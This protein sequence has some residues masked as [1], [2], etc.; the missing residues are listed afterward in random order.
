[1]KSAYDR[2]RPPHPLVHTTLASFPSG[3]A[4]AT[5]T[6]AV[7]LVIAF[8][9]SGHH[10]VWWAT[11][12][13][14]FAFLMALSRVYLSAHWLS[15]AIEG[16]LIGVACALGPALVIEAIREGL[17]RREQRAPPEAAPEPSA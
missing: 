7:A 6:T 4:V 9:P 8:V 16:S 1:M 17:E 5:T 13:A 2:P 14:V 12:A 15:D 11:A 3:H 10:R